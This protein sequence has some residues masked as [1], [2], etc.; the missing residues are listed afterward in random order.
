MDKFGSSLLRIENDNGHETPPL[1]NHYNNQFFPPCVVK[2]LS[3][4]ATANVQLG[5]QE[6]D[7]MVENSLQGQDSQVRDV[8]EVLVALQ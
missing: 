3:L 2:C 7:V 5:E 4:Y 1:E 6:Q 8:A